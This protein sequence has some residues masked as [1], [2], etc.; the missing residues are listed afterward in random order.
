MFLRA[1][2][3]H[4]TFWASI[5]DQPIPSVQIPCRVASSYRHSPRLMGGSPITHRFLNSSSTY[6]R[7]RYPSASSCKRVYDWFPCQTTLPA[8]SV[9]LLHLQ[10][11]AR[12][13]RARHLV[14]RCSASLL[15]FNRVPYQ[16]DLTITSCK[17]EPTTTFW[18]GRLIELS[19]NQ[20]RTPSWTAC[21][22]F[23]ANVTASSQYPPCPDRHFSKS[24]PSAIRMPISPQRTYRLLFTLGSIK[25]THQVQV[26]VIDLL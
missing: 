20:I 11:F 24:A 3:L 4:A 6:L 17:H 14:Q 18:H 26:R 5:M 9:I 25:V 1:S 10:A 22:I 12:R 21:A 16:H 8:S 19:P 15:H 13:L 23:Q 2:R 7:F